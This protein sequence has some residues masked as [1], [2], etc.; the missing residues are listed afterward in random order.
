[1]RNLISLQFAIRRRLGEIMAPPQPKSKGQECH[2]YPQQPSCQIPDLWFLFETYFGKRSQGIFVEVGAYDG[3]SFSN[4]WGLAEAGWAGWLVEPVP[5]F[6]QACRHHHAGHPNV[7]V[8]EIAIGAEDD[9]QIQLKLAG[10]LTTSNVELFDAYKKI[11]W[12]ES[13]LT[14]TIVSVRSLTLNSFL[15]EKMIPSHFDLLVV[16]V[17][18]MEASVFAGFDVSRWQPKMLIVELC[19]N[20]PDLQRIAKTDR[21]LYI[22]ILESGYR[23]VYKDSINTVFVSVKAWNSAN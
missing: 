2:Q 3:V 18:G 21:S 8:V 15:V 19:D 11:E 6:A 23:V 17:E 1:M 5:T 22:N 12:A 14:E 16:D 20:H 10:T 13:E 7:E 4:T 9:A